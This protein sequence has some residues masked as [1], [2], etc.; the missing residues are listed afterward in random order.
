V[1]PKGKQFVLLIRYPPYYSYIRYS[2]AYGSYK[3]F[4]DRRF[5]LIRKLHNQGFLVAKFKSS[6]RKSSWCHRDLCI[7]YGWGICFVCHTHLLSSFMNYDLVCNK[8]TKIGVA[9]GIC[10]NR[11]AL[12]PT[13]VF[14][15]YRCSVYTGYIDK[16]VSTLGLHLMF[17]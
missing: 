9:S 8:N 17:G 13:I 12:R 2:R 4:I 11:I 15:K 16:D 1:L 6:L 14:G 5:L 3:D 10:L 7:R